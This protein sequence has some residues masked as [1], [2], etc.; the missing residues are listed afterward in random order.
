MAA[1]LHAFSQRRSEFIMWP[2]GNNDKI[3]FAETITHPNATTDSIY[4]I[5][6]RFIL[7]RFAGELNQVS[8]D[9]QKHLIYLKG[10]Y[11]IPVEELG[12]RGKGY[13]SF[14][15]NISCYNR[16]LRYKMTDFKHLGLNPD[17]V[18]GGALENETAEIG[19][20]LFPRKYWQNLRSR[21]YYRIQTTI[22]QLKEAI[23]SQL[24]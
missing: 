22:E 4:G 18:Y 24:E 2:Y 20:A 15:L 13:F 19:G 10:S 3:Q 16:G 9:D 7:S 14:T 11:L 17:C 12:E 6:K 8:I 1:G 5:A 23:A 21:V